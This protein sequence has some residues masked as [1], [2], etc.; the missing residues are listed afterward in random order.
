[1]GVWGGAKGRFSD[2]A[3]FHP[4]GERIATALGMSLR[5]RSSPAEGEFLFEID[6][7]PIEESLTA[8]GGVPLL[9]RTLRS[10]DV[11]GNVRRHV[12]T[13]K[14]QRGFDEA[15]YIESF[16]VL[17]AVGG[18]CPDDF[19]TLREDPGLAEMLGHEVPSPEAARK[20]LYQF[21]DEQAT[22]Q[23]QQQLPLGRVSAIA[24]ENEPLHGL[25]EV[26]QELVR[27]L[28][29]RSRQKIA[30]VDLDATIIESRKREAQPTYQGGRGYQPM[31]ALCAEL[32][33]V[34]AD[35]FRDGNV[36]AIQEPLSMARRAFEALPETVE[37][38][39]FRGDAACY[40]TAL[41]DWLREENREN[42]PQ[43]FIGFAVSAPMTKP[44]RQAIVEGPAAKWETYRDDA[45]AFVECAP[46][47]YYRGE[48]RAED[49]RQ[50]LRYLAIRVTNKQKGLFADGGAAK[51][52]AV[53]TN[54]WE[55][56]PRR[57]LEWH[58]EKQGSI[59]ALHDMLKNE[60]AAGMMPCGRFGANAAWLRLNVITHN[61]L[62][63][64]KRLA[65]PPELLRARPK[66]LRFL[67]FHTPGKLVHHAR[68]TL[69][70]LPRAWRRFSNWRWALEQLPLPAS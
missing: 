6:E 25:A 37:E 13:K 46:V 47:D 36:P 60:L 9:A 8:L 63:A 2:A 61:T 31:L 19:E 59:E 10:L 4:K 58:R 17:Q 14:R 12:T 50:P 21:H 33:V 48:P 43:G 28:G 26:D 32:D 18:D 65:L 41:L 39:D 40:E 29:R 1:M 57:L 51:Y 68:R 67:I 22:R 15:T 54:L 64:M 66:R 35:Q 23:A 16:V 11:P 45:E 52:F 24:A 34:V 44:L 42:G 27:E 3:V 56:K 7:H 38:F 69:L 30:T 49:Y 5:K 53:V 70:G 62:T 55:W 20:F